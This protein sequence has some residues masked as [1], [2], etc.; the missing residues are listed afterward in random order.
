[1][2]RFQNTGTASA[3]N[4]RILDTLHPKLDWNTLV[5]ITASHDYYV[6]TFNGNQVEFIFEDINLPHEA[7]NEPESHGFIAYKI[8]PKIDVQVGDII[9]GDARIY[10]DF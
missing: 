8:K 9:S 4:V 10:F 1:I 6:H 7:E 5:P 3:I 2:V